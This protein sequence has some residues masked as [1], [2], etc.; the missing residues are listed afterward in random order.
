[1]DNQQLFEKH[2]RAAT[3]QAFWV[4]AIVGGMSVGVLAFLVW[5]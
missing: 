3:G 1:M 4:G 5:A 2:L